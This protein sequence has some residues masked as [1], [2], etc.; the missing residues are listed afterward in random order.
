MT[1]LRL[2]YASRPIDFTPATLND[3]LNIARRCNE[4]DDITG[5]LIAREDLYLQLLEGPALAVDQAYS[6]IRQDLRHDNIRLLLRRQTDWRLF[7]GWTLRGTPAKDWVW[8]REE[9]AAGAPAKASRPEVE[10]IFFRLW[11]EGLS[12]PVRGFRLRNR[13]RT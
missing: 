6:R 5:E 4:R 1:Y 2:I 3:I 13:T 11:R 12:T 8:T 7:P 10:A 9:V